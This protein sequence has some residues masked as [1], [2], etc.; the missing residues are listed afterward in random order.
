MS[1]GLTARLIARSYEPL[2]GTNFHV[3]PDAAAV[4]PK[5][6]GGWIYASNS[7]TTNGGVGAIHFDSNGEMT[8][9]EMILDTTSQ[10]CG[11]GKF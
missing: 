7:E 3:D 1:V 11:G 5:S 6:D 9:Y 8:N 2:F 4:F 10:N